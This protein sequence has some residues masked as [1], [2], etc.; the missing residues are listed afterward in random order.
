MGCILSGSICNG[1]G[2]TAGPTDGLRKP[3]TG[4]DH[5]TQP[6]QGQEYPRLQVTRRVW[7][8]TVLA[9]TCLTVQIPINTTRFE[10]GE[11]KNSIIGHDLDRS[12]AK[13]DIP[14][15]DKGLGV[16]V[17]HLQHRNCHIREASLWISLP[18]GIPYKITRVV[19]GAIA[20]EGFTETRKNRH[21]HR[22][23]I[24]IY[25]SDGGSN[26]FLCYLSPT[27]DRQFAYAYTLH[28]AR[29]IPLGKMTEHFTFSLG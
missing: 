27:L 19:S 10:A 6:V 17:G 8:T 24:L 21:V 3:R 15:S 2:R 4:P 16:F 13:L 20:V 26:L 18:V 11:C 29:T 9:K 7:G 25:S 28:I 12:V 23:L 14:G 22:C 5:G 1:P